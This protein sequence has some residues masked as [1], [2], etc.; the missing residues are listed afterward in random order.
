VKR[1]VEEHQGNV[2]GKNNE[3]GGASFIISLPLNS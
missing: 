2:V 1:I 3:N